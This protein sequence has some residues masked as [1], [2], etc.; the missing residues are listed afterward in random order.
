MLNRERTEE[1]QQV[2]FSL[3]A[4]DNFQRYI[5]FLKDEREA[6][7]LEASSDRVISDKRLLQTYL[8][9]VRAYTDQIDRYNAFRQQMEENVEQSRE[10]Q[11]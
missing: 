3:V 5:E 7:M 8:G 10:V 9:S 11:S 2:M 4:N 1:F 6:V